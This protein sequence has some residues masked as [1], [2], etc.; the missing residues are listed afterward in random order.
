MNR[1]RGYNQSNMNNHNLIQSDLD[2][3]RIIQMAW[4][5]RTPFEAIEAQFGLK[6]SEVKALMKKE[7]R[8]SSYRNWRQRVQKCYTKHLRKR[9]EN[10]QRFKCDRQRSISNNRISKR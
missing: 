4:E 9:P 1:K 3:D 8:F 6:E 10:I 7:L 5:D 2:K